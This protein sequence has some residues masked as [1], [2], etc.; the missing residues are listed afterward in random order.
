MER[1]DFRH[2][3]KH[4][5]NYAGLLAILDYDIRTAITC[6]G[7]LASQ[8]VTLPIREAPIILEVARQFRMTMAVASRQRFRK[9]VVLEHFL[10]WRKYAALLR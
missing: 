9:S 8:C 4:E 1:V 6:S 2:E 7:F 5:I 3:W 10:F